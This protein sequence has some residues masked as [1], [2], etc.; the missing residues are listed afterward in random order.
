MRSPAPRLDRSFADPSGN[1]WPCGHNYVPGATVRLRPNF[2]R[3]FFFSIV[4]ESFILFFSS[5][6]FLLTSSYFLVDTIL[7]LLILLLLYFKLFVVLQTC[8]IYTYHLKGWREG[9]IVKIF[10][11]LYGRPESESKEEKKH[12]LWG[13]VGTLCRS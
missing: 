13:P 5:F 6:Q 7:R 2:F 11:V 4:F 8:M 10:F 12:G 3:F 1:I 9:G